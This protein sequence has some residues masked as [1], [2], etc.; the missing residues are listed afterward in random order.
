M[1]NSRSEERSWFVGSRWIGTKE[2]LGWGSSNVDPAPRPQVMVYGARII[3]AFKT[4]TY[5]AVVTS[6]FPPKFFASE[7]SGCMGLASF[8]D[9]FRPCRPQTLTFELCEC[10]K[11]I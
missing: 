8:S 6:R 9:E 7:R 2:S 10:I 11:A 3:E 4:V 1:G 5:A